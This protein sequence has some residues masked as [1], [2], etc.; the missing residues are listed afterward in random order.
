MFGCACRKLVMVLARWRC[1][2]MV[3][4]GKVLYEEVWVMCG[5][6]LGCY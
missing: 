4:V 1:L 3:I 6:V 2:V 5:Y